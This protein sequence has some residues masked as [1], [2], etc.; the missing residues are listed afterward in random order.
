MYITT[1]SPS[2]SKPLLINR[3]GEELRQDVLNIC[4]KCM[5]K[6]NCPYKDHKEHV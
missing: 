1:P 5:E 2:K 3:A 6:Y 4:M